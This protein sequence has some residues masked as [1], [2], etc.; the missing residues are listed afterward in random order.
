MN[1]LILSVAAV[2]AVLSF[3][4][5]PRVDAQTAPDVV[6][7][8]SLVSPRQVGAREIRPGG[9]ASHGAANCVAAA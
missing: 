3:V 6:G 8:W 1:H 7:T 4:A 5:A 9:L 2:S